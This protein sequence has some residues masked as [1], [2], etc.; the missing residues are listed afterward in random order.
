VPAHR[1]FTSVSRRVEVTSDQPLDSDETQDVVF[2][3][4]SWSVQ[5]VV[6]ARQT[7]TP[8]HRN[9]RQVTI[10]IP[11]YMTLL[12]VPTDFRQPIGEALSTGS[13]WTLITS[14]SNYEN[15][16]RFAQSHSMHGAGKAQ[17]RHERLCWTFIAGDNEGG[18][19]RPCR[20]LMWD[21]IDMANIVQCRLQLS[22]TK[23][24]AVF[25]RVEHTVISPK[26]QQ[27][28]L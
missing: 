20:A 19:S 12:R 17:G 21:P 6:A 10:Y 3:L 25:P 1:E 23:D 27:H 22:F 7:T 16:V 15:R 26:R 8:K 9:L 28:T 11:C 2:R 4:N 18:D 14:W 24:R 13:S 5:R